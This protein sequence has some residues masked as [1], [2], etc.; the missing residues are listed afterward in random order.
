[1]T[2][3]LIET[4][5]STSVAVTG[6]LLLVLLSRRAVTRHF[7]ARVAYALW[8]LPALRL[9]MPTI[10][11]PAAW[12][13]SR[14]MPSVSPDKADPA[15]FYVGVYS[16]PLPITDA[17]STLIWAD[18]WPTALVMI[19]G[20][21]IIVSVVWLI[22]RQHRY[23]RDL[24]RMSEAPDAALAIEIART[25]RLSGLKK[26]PTIRV[27]YNN[28]GPM[29]YGLWRPVIV[30]PTNFTARFTRQQRHLAL[31]HE[32]VHV[33]RGDLWTASAMMLFRLMNWPNPL[34]HLAWPRFRA[35]QEAAC[36]AAVLRLTG[37]AARADYAQTLL[38]A[39]KTNTQTS[40]R[41]GPMSGTGL[42]LSLH[43][44]IKERLMTLGLSTNSRRGASRWGLAAVL[45]TGAALTAPI[46]LADGPPE[47]TETKS[48]STTSIRSIEVV[49]EQAGDAEKAHF[50]IKDKDGVQ[51]YLRVSRD[52]TK[53]VLTRE[54][55]EAEYGTEFDLTSTQDG[56]FPIQRFIANVDGE[57][58][59]NAM[60]G[61]PEIREQ[62]PQV[63]F[64]TAGDFDGASIEVIVE[65]G[66]RKVMK[67]E[68]DG[69]RT[70]L[71]LEK[72]DALPKTGTI[73]INSQLA[74]PDGAEGGKFKSFTVNNDMTKWVSGDGKQQRFTIHETGDASPAMAEGRLRAAQ[75][76]LDSTDQ[77]V[78]NLRE[79]AQGDAEKD[80]RDAV[81]QLEKARKALDKARTAIE[82]SGGR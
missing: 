11:I 6:L 5:L 54:Q 74:F 61:L 63:F 69:T 7:G 13:P 43:H 77:L 37:E 4:G 58:G 8:L 32:L 21:G 1:V 34:V 24:M 52:G 76:M 26:S 81:R 49:R 40:G 53:E 64:E 65:D 25:I 75:T 79:T 10:P 16:P 66:E 80:L 35:D 42:T 20:V 19:W 47:V 12:G 30:L 82:K 44:P 71:D 51:T 57:P 23:G 28:D 22:I 72:M 33:R 3:T 59:L 67:I 18:I 46:T 27:S 14:W 70:E 78:A 68:K 56:A 17:P 29:V 60:N 62:F 45:L 31:L 36:D 2:E 73:T 48:S 9:I 39:A 38:T 41:A 15:P 55:F 50:Q